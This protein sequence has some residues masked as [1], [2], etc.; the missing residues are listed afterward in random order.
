M[1]HIH[2][3]SGAGTVGQIA[4]DIPSGLC[5]TPPQQIK[6]K[7]LDRKLDGPNIRSERLLLAGINPDSL[8]VQPIA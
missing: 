4:A 3:S 7:N 6:L 1:L 8:A 2:L 5:L